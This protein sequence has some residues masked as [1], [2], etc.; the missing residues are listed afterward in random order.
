MPQRW[1]AVGYLRTSLTV[2]RIAGLERVDRHVL[3]A[4]VLE[5]AGDVRRATD[6]REVAEEDP[7]PDEPL[8]EVLDQ[9]VLDVRGGHRGDE[10]RQQEEDP[11]AGHQRE[12]R[13]SG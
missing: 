5:D 12:Q 2:E 6:Q 9:A 3:G 13:A 4:V 10:Q 8:D 1:W 7:D 11:D